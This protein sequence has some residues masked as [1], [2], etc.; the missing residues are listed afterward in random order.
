MYATRFRHVSAPK[1]NDH[2]PVTFL[3]PACRRLLFPLLHAEKDVPSSNFA[4]TMGYLNSASNNAALDCM[5]NISEI[6]PL[7]KVEMYKGKI[8]RRDRYKG[9]TLLP[10]SC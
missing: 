2:G 5:G 4:L 7:E 3:L 6:L 1:T 8:L 10:E 9:C